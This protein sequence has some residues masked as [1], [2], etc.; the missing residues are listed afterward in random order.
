[1]HIVHPTT[2]EFIVARDQ[3][4]QDALRPEPLPYG[5]A[6]EYP[7]V[8]GLNHQF[9]YCAIKDKDVV[10]HF[11]LWPRHLKTYGADTTFAVGLVGN[12]ATRKD[13]RGQGIMSSL[14]AK[15]VE[16]A[17]EKQLQALILWSDLHSFY[18]KQGFEAL[19][20]E[21]RFLFSP[22]S[23]KVARQFLPTPAKSLT[24][25][26][27]ND[28]LTLTFKTPARI[29]R[30]VGEF[31]ALLSIPST[32]IFLHRQQEK[33]VAFGIVGKGYDMAGV[34][35]EWGCRSPKEAV[36][37][38]SDI[39]QT[40]AWPETMLLCPGNLPPDWDHYLAKQSKSREAHPMALIRAKKNSAV[41][42]CL[43]SSFIWGLDSI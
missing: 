9:S 37:L 25:S 26:D 16:L 6:S 13:L 20:K 27:I 38:V 23:A 24:E 42:R 7:L 19:G 21:V 4:L 29:E 17:N 10:A 32:A 34:I 3:L 33:I 30:S 41:R 1:M 22:T 15:L 40:F 35:H 31:R 14:F 2:S 39:Q 12:V 28:L 5:I 11:N 43:E 8:L 36:Q 18:Q